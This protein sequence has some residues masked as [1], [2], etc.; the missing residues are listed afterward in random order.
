LWPGVRALLTSRLA[1]WQ[2]LMLA[3]LC[4]GMATRADAAALRIRAL[5]G[6]RVE[7]R[8]L[9]AGARAHVLALDGRRVARTRRHI[10]RFSIWRDRGRRP[11]L[12]VRRPGS[13]TPLARARFTVAAAHNRAAP[14]LLLLATPPGRIHGTRA[15][16]RFSASRHLVR[17]RR[18]RLPW[19]RC[20]S[21]VTFKRLASGPHH[22]SVRTAN[23][24]GTATVHVTTTVVAPARN[25]PQPPPPSGPKPVFADEFSGT[26]VNTA[27]WRVYDSA[28]NAG[29]GLRRPSAVALDGAGHLVITARTVD[30]QVVSG[31]MANRLGMTYGRFVFRVR[32]DSDPTGT[33]SGVV[34][35]WPDSERWPENGEEDIYE[36]GPAAGTRYPFHSYVH[37]GADNR[38]YRFTHL[39]DGAQWHTMEMDWRPGAIRFYRDGS[40]A[41]IVTDPAAIPHVPH[42]LDVQLDA[43]ANTTLPAPV[44]LYVDYV[45]IYR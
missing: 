35:T 21:P 39:A 13:P 44:R 38:Q 23:R 33:M 30:G 29:N 10:V 17:C 42:H 6:W 11:R 8:L 31:G 20:T 19:R 45:R 7:V 3:V 41:G 2:V 28:G 43:Y 25:A 15:T 34:L 32:T 5:P 24:H 12:V 1:R 16:L 36:T 18:D 9:G 40:L 22:L 37:Y 14:T 4:A 26:T 27:D